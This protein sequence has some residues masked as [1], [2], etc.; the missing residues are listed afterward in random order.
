MSYT[1]RGIIVAACAITMLC[2]GGT[3]AYTGQRTDKNEASSV[4]IAGKLKSVAHDSSLAGDGT[5]SLPLKIVVHHGDPILGDGMIGNGTAQFPLVIVGPL[6]LQNRSDSGILEAH[7]NDPD[8]PGIV[9]ESFQSG[10]G[11]F[12]ISSKGIG[13]IGQGTNDT[14]VLGESSNGFGVEGTGFSGVRGFG[15][16]AGAVGVV[17]ESPQQGA[18][19]TGIFG[20]AHQGTA[21]FFSGRVHATAGISSAANITQIDHPDDPATKYLYHAGVASP[22]LKNFYDGIATTDETG[23][24]T[25]LLPDYFTAYNRDYRYQLTVVGQFAQAIV[26]EKIRGNR[27]T[28]KTDKPGVEV[29]WQVTGIR[30]DAWAEAQQFSAERE[31]PDAEKGFYLHPELFGQGEDRGIEWAQHPKIM[32]EM[33][34]RRSHPALVRK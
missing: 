27:F 24:A 25:V 29:S 9:G 16:G 13:V 32:K 4:R 7:N 15:T 6:F 34:V 31:K 3:S 19:A 26:A 17:G 10:I 28:I 20:I 30:H 22:D 5:P 14:G 11:V 1:M 8:G 2:I 21:G 12:G 18:N 33:R 23:S